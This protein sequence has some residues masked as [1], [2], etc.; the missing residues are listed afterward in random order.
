MVFLLQD[1]RDPRFV[2]FLISVCTVNGL[3]MPKIQKYITDAV[4]LPS[5]TQTLHAKFNELDANRDQALSMKEFM[6]G[7]WKQG[8]SH[9]QSQKLFAKIDANSMMIVLF[10]VL[11]RIKHRIPLGRVRTPEFEAV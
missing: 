4:L 5:S 11:S 7:E 10:I 8:R 6:D 2:D 1:D 3:P 9:L